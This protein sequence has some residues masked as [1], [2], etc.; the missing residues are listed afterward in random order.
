[1]KRRLWIFLSF[2][3]L[4]MLIVTC[5]KSEQVENKRNDPTAESDSSFNQ[6]AVEILR[7]KLNE[8]DIP[9]FYSNVQ[10]KVIGY[11]EEN[12]IRLVYVKI[13][14]TAS[15]TTI[16]MGPQGFEKLVYIGKI[17]DGNEYSKESIVKFSKFGNSWLPHPPE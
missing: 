17:V 9:R 4:F 15:R 7:A 10:I 3:M 1:M 6:Y 2:V 8:T 14:A 16:V 5:K 12:D 11:K 13:S